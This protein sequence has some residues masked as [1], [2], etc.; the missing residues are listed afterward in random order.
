AEISLSSATSTTTGLLAAW[1]E[2]SSG[3]L[4]ASTGAVRLINSYA[5]RRRPVGRMP[6]GLLV[7]PVRMVDAYCTVFFA[8][9][10][11]EGDE[12]L[13]RVMH[14][15]D[16][17]PTAGFLTDPRGLG[18]TGEVLVGIAED[19]RIQ[20]VLPYRQSSPRSDI[21]RGGL[22]PLTLACDGLFGFVRTT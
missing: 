13:G 1:I 17:A 19:D 2:D 15:F 6:A 18:E 4:L 5:R 12:R 8:D 21:S 20:L 9:I 16:F 7:P 3:R 22:P 14:L 11:G 10:R